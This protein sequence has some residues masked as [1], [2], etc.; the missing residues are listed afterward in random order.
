MS[1]PL[2]PKPKTLV[3]FTIGEEKIYGTVSD[4]P[5]QEGFLIYYKCPWTAD[6]SWVAS[7]NCRNLKIEKP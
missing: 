1:D 6:K 5:L 2:P 4:T 3:S 7:G